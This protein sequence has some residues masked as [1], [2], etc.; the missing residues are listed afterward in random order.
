MNYSSNYDLFDAL[1]RI[2][3]YR[4]KIFIFTLLSAFLGILLY[5]ILPKKYEADATFIL[6]NPQ[7]ADRSNM[8]N[9]ETKFV[10]YYG[11][12]DDIDRLTTISWSDTVQNTVIRTM[13]LAAVYNYDTTKPKE[14]IKL[15]R[16]FNRNLKIRRTESKSIIL[17]YCDKDPQRAADVVSLSISLI[18]KSLRG[19]YNSMRNDM[20]QSILRKANDDEANITM[21]TDSLIKLRQQY[22][23][24][25]IISPSRYNT[26]M[27]SMK[28][29]GNPDFARG[30]ELIQNIESVKDELVSDRTRHLTLANQYST[31]T[32][33]N[34]MPLIHMVKQ[35][36][37]PLRPKDVYIL[38]TIV[39]C[40][41]LG[42]LFSV[43]YVLRIKEP[44]D[45]N[46]A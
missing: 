20:Y 42:F 32:Q 23:I 37:P 15:R 41:L 38:E 39:L 29:N 5:F 6:K 12:E 43:V 35:A 16:R 14:V 7:Y 22:K 25:D 19:F 27:G 26:I 45:K 30:V 10:D 3:K 8:Y 11:N 21:L 2:S 17:S 34:E 31:H 28:D 13:N 4:K 9:N 1:K 46:N 44:A 18:E 24:Y 36:Q 33:I 40:T